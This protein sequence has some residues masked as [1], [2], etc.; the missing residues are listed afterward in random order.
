MQRGG[1]QAGYEP[2]PIAAMFAVL[3]IPAF[4]LQAL[5]RVDAALIGRPVALLV[6]GRRGQVI[7]ECNDLAT[8]AGVVP[9]HSAPRAQAR[10][11]GIILRTRQA[12]L[13]R[14]AF[15]ALLA[16]AFGIT[17]Y[18]EATAPG[19]CTLGLDQLAPA[20]RLPALQRALEQLAL[21]GLPASAGLAATPL[22]ALYAA[23]HAASGQVLRGD[24]DFLAVL[25][26]AAADPPPE[27]APVLATW[28]LHTLGQLTALTKADVA[29]RLGRDGL[30]LWE[31]AAGE[32]TRPLN[33]A[34]PARE[35]AARF[36]CEHEL[37]TLEPLLF[38]L[39][40]FV[41]RL[42]LELANAHQAALAI[43]L[44]LDLADDTQHVQS[45]RL[46][47]PV[48]DA[49]ILFRALHTHLETVR[50]TAGI[51]GVRLRLEAG[52]IMVRQQ[53]L[54]DGGLRDPHGFA[55]TLARVIALVGPGRAGRPVPGDTHQPDVFT[56][57]A[58][59]AT[60]APLR[61][62]FVHPPRGLPL[63]RYRPPTPARVAVTD[64]RPAYV[65]AAGTEGAVAAVTGPWIGSGHWWEHGRFW[66]HE[67]WD[68][69][70]AGGGLYRLQHTTGGWFIE[71][72]Y[73]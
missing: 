70:M 43:E 16:A 1:V 4:A 34:A 15:D 38:I 46:P 61:D 30:A 63:R 6:P 9:G 28:G 18:V 32:T 49:N 14:E 69:E 37:E 67:E 24:R 41:D 23:R 47:E 7:E 71:G 19:I 29:Q 65:W 36:D 55:D 11:P 39:R 13:E 5:L 60:L 17:A 3:H 20:R 54:F 8:A 59:P 72:E 2:S 31:R 10:C 12:D 48:T 64:A 50:T 26:V 57:I 68:V 44:T 53:G 62:G 45:I 58:P 40:R 42:A 25:P 66:H 22:L 52:R 56:L 51:A 27:L 73:D 35:F 33:V 21:L